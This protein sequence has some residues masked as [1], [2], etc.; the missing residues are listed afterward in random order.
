MWYSKY[1]TRL[2]NNNYSKIDGDGGLFIT[3]WLPKEATQ[4]LKNIYDLDEDLRILS[5]KAHD[6]Q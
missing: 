2:S 4:A 5:G 3:T 1:I 6:L